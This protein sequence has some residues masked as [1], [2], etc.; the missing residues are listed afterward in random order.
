M[1]AITKWFWV[2]IE[3]YLSYLLPKFEDLVPSSLGSGAIETRRKCVA[4]TAD[5]CNRRTNSPP[6][7]PSGTKVAGCFLTSFLLLPLAD[8]DGDGGARGAS[9]ASMLLTCPARTK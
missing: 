6:P 8:G 5:Y 3:G 9:K 7:E 4:V 2:T 1:A